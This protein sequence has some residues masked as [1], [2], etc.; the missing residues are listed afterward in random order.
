MSFARQ[1]TEP[2]LSTLVPNSPSINEDY[3]S[4]INSRRYSKEDMDKTMESLNGYCMCKANS[5]FSVTTTARYAADFL[6]DR[7]NP[8]MSSQLESD[9][10]NATCFDHDAPDKKYLER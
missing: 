9:V 7:I 4:Y 8:I 3:E 6:K 5:R 1:S 2:T 10:I